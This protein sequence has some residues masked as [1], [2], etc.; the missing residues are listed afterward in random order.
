MTLLWNRAQ[1]PLHKLHNAVA[2]LVKHGPSNQEGTGS[3]PVRGTIVL[4]QDNLSTLL[5][6]TQEYKWVPR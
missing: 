3:N 5:L 6:S 4:Q 1:V 2:W